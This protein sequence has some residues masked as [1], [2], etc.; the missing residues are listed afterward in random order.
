MVGSRVSETAQGLVEYVIF[1]DGPPVLLAH[2]VIG[3]CDHGPGLAENYVGGGF[4]VIA[5]SRFGYLRSPLPQDSSATAQA[6]LY[7]ALLDEL[8]LEQVC[9]AG[10]SAGT[11]SVLRFAITYPERCSSVVL[12]SMAVPPYAVPSTLR[13]KL[14]RRFFGSDVLWWALTRFVPWPLRRLMGIPASVDRSLTKTD[15][16]WANRVMYSFLPVSLRTNGVM[17]DV[18]FS[19]PDLN[20]PFPFEAMRIPA[21]VLHA[22]DDPWGSCDGAAAMAARMPLAKFETIGDGG[23]LLLGHLPRV[24][25]QIGSF[26]SGHTR[27]TGSLPAL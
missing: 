3:G 24:R 18:C 20:E 19:N 25:K 22:R 27:Q 14:M 12:W 7:A 11:S 17:N 13:L 8:N 4:R 2:G 5:P 23:H 10:T 16:S 21:L 1:G 26:I 9:V 6:H 15:R